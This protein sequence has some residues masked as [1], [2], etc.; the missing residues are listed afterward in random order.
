[1]QEIHHLKVSPREVL[2]K[3]EKGSAISISMG[4]ALRGKEESQTREIETHIVIGEKFEK[5][6]SE[7]TQVSMKFSVQS[8]TL[9]RPFNAELHANGKVQRPSQEWD[10]Q[11]LLKEDLT[12]KVLIHGDYGFK[13][14][15]KENIK[16]TIHAFRSDKQ[17]E[18]VQQSEEYE[19]CSRDES[20][21]RKLTRDCKNTRHHAASLDKVQAKLSL[22]K[23]IVNSRITEL[24]TEAAKLYTLPYL[25]QRSIEKRNSRQ[26]EEEYD[27]EAE[28]DGRGHAL[29]VKIAGNGEEVEARNVQ[30]TSATKGLLP[31]CTR[32]N[33]GTKIMQKLTNYNSPSSCTLESG[34]VNTF[35]RYEYD[36]A[37]NDC[38]HIIFTESSSRPRVTVSA[39][40]SPQKQEVTMV[41]DGHKYQVEISKQ[42][43]YSRDNKATI[44]VNG[45]VKE[46]KSLEQQQQWRQQ[47]QQQLQQQQQQ[48]QK[49]YYETETYNVYEDED[50]YVVNSED[51]VYTILSKKYGVSV[52]AD[53]KRIEVNSY[54]QIFR[55]KATGL[56]GDL[57]GERT[58]DVKSSRRCMTS[59]PEISALSFMIEDGKCKGIAQQEKSELQRE[60]QRCVKKEEIP[61][62]VS[63]IFRSELDSNR[64]P[65]LRHITEE[66]KGETCFSKNL[67]RVCSRTYPKEIKAQRVEFTCIAGSK[68]ESLKRQVQAGELVEQ[69]TKSTTSSIKIV[70]VPTEC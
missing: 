1:M 6:R 47:Q 38:E 64:Q 59:K 8:P 69:L 39:K 33:L 15:E 68:V 7:Q 58:A 23:S 4:A 55:N 31:I 36:Y 54:Q 51:G 29:F 13:G 27:I 32:Y 60:E 19:R 16:A 18:F 50:T 24:A 57:N 46:W 65:E 53:G 41:V 45:E 44:K 49:R 66:I 56:C 3:L 21:G 26:G 10:V 14:E 5:R 70:Y 48:Q 12:S 37:I 40:E 52:N 30:L 42:S 25:T 63:S 61:T 43:R 17:V 20:E 9:R 22:P 35:D 28:V 67:I 2:N 62:R 34:K 11:E